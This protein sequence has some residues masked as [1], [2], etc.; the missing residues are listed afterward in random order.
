MTQTPSP[1]TQPSPPTSPTAPDRATAPAIALIFIGFVGL[2]IMLLPTAIAVFQPQT[3]PG[4][5]AAMPSPGWLGHMPPFIPAMKTGALGVYLIYLI[6]YAVTIWGGIKMLKRKDYVLA[7][8]AAIIQIIPGVG[9]YYVVGI[10]F[11]I[12]ALMVLRKPEVKASFH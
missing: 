6:L 7:M 5:G 12:W 10:P 8:A 9:F 1:L 2:V 11:G 3:L 4:K